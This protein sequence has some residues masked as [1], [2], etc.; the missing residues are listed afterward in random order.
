MKLCLLLLFLFFCTLAIAHEGHMEQQHSPSEGVEEV[1]QASRPTT[2]I[3]WIGS[4]HLIF[5]HFPIALINM[6]TVAEIMFAWLKRPIFAFSAQF[7]LISA[8]L[9]AAPTA[10]LGLV[11]SYSVPYTGSIETTL[12]WHMWLGLTTAII[13]AVAVVIRRQTE[14]SKLYYAC[15]FLLFFSVNC[16]AYFGAEMTFGPFYIY[17]PIASET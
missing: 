14:L 13:A 9:I 6:L 3:Q 11:Y 1:A 8:A 15:L 16:T 17:P 10:A 7:L 12:L 2:W 5:L 4:F